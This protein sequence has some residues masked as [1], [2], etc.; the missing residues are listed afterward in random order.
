[1]KKWLSILF[2][3]CLFTLC[4]ACSNV[5][6]KKQYATSLPRELL[7]EGDEYSVLA[8][9]KSIDHSEDIV[10][11]KKV[12]YLSPLDQVKEEY[13]DL[14]IKESPFFIVF[15]DKEI[16]LRTSSLD[17]ALLFIKENY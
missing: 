6:W 12:K 14:G 4:A 16:V 5:T 1:M 2:I 7:S 8:V 15:N 9:G 11:L 10:G 3:I 13:P 17:K